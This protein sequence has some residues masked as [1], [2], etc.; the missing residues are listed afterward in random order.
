MPVRAVFRA[1]VAKEYAIQASTLDGT[2]GGA[3]GLYWRPVD[4][5]AWL[6][7]MGSFTDAK[8]SQ[9]DAV[10]LI[11]AGSLATDADGSTLY[12]ASPLGLTAFERDADT[13]AIDGRPVG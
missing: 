5:P 9:G 12:A 2:Y 3:F 6:R 1:E 4:P 10:Q 7:Y 8:D 13:G 11:N